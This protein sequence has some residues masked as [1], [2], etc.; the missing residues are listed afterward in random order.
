MGVG[1]GEGGRGLLRLGGVALV[2]AREAAIGLG[3]GPSVLGPIYRSLGDLYMQ[4]KIPELAIQNYKQAEEIDPNDLDTKMALGEAYYN[5]RLY[6]DALA[7]YK[8]VVAADSDYS[9]GY[10]KL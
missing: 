7:E 10:L 9:D 1:E 2:Q 8:Q 6:N 4:R 5:G 3:G